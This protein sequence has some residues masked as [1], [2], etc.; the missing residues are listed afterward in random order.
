MSDN[1]LSKHT[2][3]RRNLV[4][5][6]VYGG[7]VIILSV[8][9][10]FIKSPFWL[11]VF[12]LTFI[13]IV[14]TVSFRTIAIS[15]QFHLAHAAFMGVGAYLAGM[16]SKWFGWPS[17]L[18]IPLAA[19][20]TAGIGMLIGYPFARLRALYYAL[21]SLFFGLT[22]VNIIIAAKDWTGGWPGLTGIKPL[23]SGAS[24]IHYYYFFLGLTSLCLAALYRFEFSR[25][26]IN[27]K[28]IAQSYMVASSVGI[29]EAFYRILAMGVGCFFA[30]LAGATYAHY[31]QLLS[32][33]SFNLLATLWIVMY[34]VIGGIDNFPGPI[35]G[36]AFLIIVPEFARALREYVPFISAAML[37]IVIFVMPKGL[38][39]LPQLIKSHFLEHPEEPRPQVGASSRKG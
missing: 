35:I 30:G 8:L 28:A 6:S 24:K 21:G 27:L 26:G 11:H 32:W 10:L 3:G 15:G 1:Q 4:K 20:A 38:A 39:G 14:V 18:T 19:L 16:A 34:V 22:I 17:W 9:P 13:Y 2:I 5:P 31:N 12:I 29:N 7:V 25:I 23:I 37:L 33:T 36:T